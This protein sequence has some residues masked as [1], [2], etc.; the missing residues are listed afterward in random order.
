MTKKIKQS[1]TVSQ[2]WLAI[3]SRLVDSFV[4]QNK[5]LQNNKRIKNN[6]DVC[7]YIVYDLLYKKHFDRNIDLEY[8]S[9]NYH[10]L[11]NWSQ[12]GNNFPKFFRFLLDRHI[13]ERWQ[14]ETINP[15]TNRPYAYCFH[16]KG[17]VGTCA[18]YKLNTKLIRCMQNTPE[19]TIYLDVSQKNDY[20]YH[21]V[22]KY[23]KKLNWWK[24]NDVY[25]DYREPNDYELKVMERLKHIQVSGQ[26]VEGQIEPVFIH[27]RIY[28]N[29]W[30]NLSKEYRGTV[31]FKGVELA[32]VFDVPN[33]YVQFLATNLQNDEAVSWQDKKLF[34]YYAYTGQF[35]N[36]LTEGT[37]YTKEDIKP[38]WMHFLFCSS[39]TKKRGLSC[40]RIFEDGQVKQMFDLEYIAKFNLIKNKMKK[41]FPAIYNYLINYP[42]IEVDER[43]VSKL[44]VD[45]QWRENQKVLNLLMKGLEEKGVLV[46]PIPLHDGIYVTK[47][48]VTEQL[49]EKIKTVWNRIINKQYRTNKKEVNVII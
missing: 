44:S 26:Y 31:K 2:R 19:T 13:I 36:H 7:L 32:E 40:Q 18:K 48:Q 22:P 27:G 20:F 35:Y 45:L 49:K 41:Q 33:C 46:E 9:L 23:K 25:G 10:N 30:T 17:V 38:I 12:L 28:Q 21:V 14:S 11:Q 43:K 5:Q 29:G 8:F 15:R 3:T 47:E 4:E 34:C 24:K 6:L 42:Q 16:S 39:G 1:V 37:E